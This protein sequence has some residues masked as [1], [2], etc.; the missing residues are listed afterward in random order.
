MIQMDLDYVP[1]L[2]IDHHHYQF[3]LQYDYLKAHFEQQ[4]FVVLQ[5]HC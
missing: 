3:H 5:E 4:L 1:S 2:T